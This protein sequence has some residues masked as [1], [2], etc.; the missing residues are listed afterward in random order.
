MAE[1]NCG[2]T[3]RTAEDYRGHLP[4]PPRGDKLD[5]AYALQKEFM[6]MLVEHDRF[7]EYP[8][9]LTTKQGQRFFKEI[10]FNLIAELMEAT[11][12]LKNK[13]HRLSDATEIDFPHFIEELGDGFAFFLEG[14]AA[15]GITPDML[16]R[17][18]S[19][20]NGIVRKRIQEG[21]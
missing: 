12:I 9:D 5:I 13:M 20:K 2:E 4:C 6:D 1:C 17:E 8:V 7:P 14:L 3:F 10:M 19:R 16:F 18:F 15:V 21:Y 11:V